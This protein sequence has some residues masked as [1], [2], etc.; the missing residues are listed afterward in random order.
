VGGLFDEDPAGVRIKHRFLDGAKRSPEGE[1]WRERRSESIAAFADAS[2]SF[3]GSAGAFGG[4]KS[5][6]GHELF[7]MLETTEGPSH[8]IV[9]SVH[10]VG[11]VDGDEVIGAKVFGKLHGVAL[12]GFDAVAGFDWDKRG[13][14]DVATN[15]HLEESPGD[16]KSAPARFVANLEVG[17]FAFLVLGDPPHGS[18]EGVLG[19][20]DG[21]VMAWFGIALT[22]ENGDDGFCFIYVESGVECLRCV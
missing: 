15:A 17:E 12:V 3:A 18:F 19:G 11:D 21:T 1:D 22:F 7:G 9:P 2:F 6:E 13:S 4:D 8:S 14:N 20:S 5:Q 16:P 10:A